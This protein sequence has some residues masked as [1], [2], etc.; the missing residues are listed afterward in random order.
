MCVTSV[1]YKKTTK[2]V[3][4]NMKIVA[5]I[6][7][8]MGSKRIKAKNLRL[9]DGKPLIEYILNTVSRVNIF[10]EVYINSEDDI[11]AEIAAKYGAQFYKRPMEFASDTATNDDFGYD[12]VKNVE[13]DLLIQILPTS[14]FVTAEEIE[15]FTQKMIDDSLDTLISVEHKQIA[16]VYNGEAIN[17]ER[18]AVNPP[19][20]T[21]TPVL[22]YATALMGWTSASFVKNYDSHGVA[23]HG[24]DGK[25]DYFE[26]RGLSTVDIDRE[27]DFR[28]AEAIV[29]SQRTAVSSEPQYYESNGKE[30]S[31]IDVPSILAR[32]G[33]MVNDLFDANNEIVQLDTILE[34]MPK[35]QSWSKRVIDNESNSMTIISQFPGEGNRKHHHPDWNEWWFIVEGEWEWEIEGEKKKIVQGDIVFMRKNRKHKITAAGNSRATRMAVSRSDVAHVYEEE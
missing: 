5:M 1:L 8:R 19:S 33:V 25:T 17:Y 21:M 16:C 6:P 11:F 30:R 18:L 24:G 10:D 12:F 23:Y 29:I 7:A 20:Q 28:L 27:E 15:A 3:R 31:E 13:C 35:D 22:A 26:L 4:E 9:L 2:N 14:P 32:D 34:S